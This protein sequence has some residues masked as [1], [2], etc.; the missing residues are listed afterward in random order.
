MDPSSCRM[1]SGDPFLAQ[2]T[3]QSTLM[4]FFSPWVKA[5]AESM[6]HPVT[7]FCSA[8]KPDALARMPR[9]METANRC[10]IDSVILRATRAVGNSW[11]ILCA[12]ASSVRLRDELRAALPCQHGKSK[13]RSAGD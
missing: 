6:T 3:A 13:Q 4:G 7:V 2:E 8:A 12:P 5:H 10:F 9:T 1:T 11:N